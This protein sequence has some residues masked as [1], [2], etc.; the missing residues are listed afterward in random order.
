MKNI[1]RL[2]VA[3]G[4]GRMSRLLTDGVH[5]ADD[6]V[7]AGVF[8]RDRAAASD[9][10]AA[11][12]LAQP[13]V[14]TVTADIDRLL[15]DTDVLIDFTR[16]EAMHVHLAA[17]LRHGVGLVIG[18]TGLDEAQVDAVRQAAT[19]VPIVFAPC[20]SLG[21][22][23]LLALLEQA[24]GM[25]DERYDIEIVEAHHRY[26]I[27]APSGT[28]LAMGDA[29]ARAR[30]RSLAEC[31]VYG[32]AGETGSRVSGAIGFAAVRGGDI[33]GEHTV[34]FIGQG[35][36]IEITHRATSRQGYVDGALD[37]ARFLRGRTSGLF[38]MRDV[39]DGS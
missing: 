24:A 17:A 8:G 12:G 15:K 1:Q 37:A 5:G 28:A 32:R 23:R 31:A 11:D 34:M 18:T 26:K 27:D 22:T 36:R 2:V 20:M 16:P 21:V 38:D 30:G 13:S 7:L 4:T 33:V 6:M 10:M 19:T 29:I 25:F 14:A 9:R 3:G 35:E 39:I